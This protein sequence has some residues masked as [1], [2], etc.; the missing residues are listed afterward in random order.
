MK[1]LF[2]LFMVLLSVASL[3]TAPTFAHP[4]P[5][6]HGGHGHGHGGHG[7]GGGYGHG[8]GHGGRGGFGR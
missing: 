4:E 6:R 7:H 8:H 5:R 1:L 3:L 2:A